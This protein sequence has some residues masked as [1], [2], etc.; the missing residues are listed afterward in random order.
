MT[1]DLVPHEGAVALPLPPPVD[2]TSPA[3]VEASMTEL[4]VAEPAMAEPAVAGPPPPVEPATAEP[5][6]AAPP[7]AEPSAPVTPPV[8]RAPRGVGPAALAAAAADADAAAP[9][10]A[11][12]DHRLTSSERRARRR[13]G[14]HRLRWSVLAVV[15]VILVAAAA[16]AVQRATKPLTAASPVSALPSSMVVPG[17]APLLPWPVVGQGAVAVPSLGYAEQSGPEPAVPIASLT[18]MANAV[19]I[20]RDHPVPAGADG[21]SI[22][23]TADDVGQYHYDLAHDESNIPIQV[24]ETLTERQMLEALLTQSA[25][26]IAYSLAVWD[27]GSEAAFVVK[28]NAL[29]ANVGAT[30]T[31][32]ADSSGY[33]PQSVSTA[34]DC[35]RI[36]AAGMVIPTFAEIV[37]MSTVSLPLV[38]EAHNIVT[39]IGSNGVV[40]IKSGYTSQAGGCMVLAAYRTINGRSTLVLASAL[41]QAV[42]PPVTPTTTTTTTVPGAPPTSAPPT[43]TTTTTIPTNDL[44]IQFPLLYTGPVVE[45]LLDATEQGVVA[46]PLASPGQVVGTVTSHWGGTAHQVRAV[47]SGR[48]TMLGWPGQRVITGTKFT[49]IPSGGAAGT[50]IGSA[51]YALGQQLASV[52]V[53]LGATLPQPSRWW[54]MVHG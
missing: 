32:Y 44:E 21:P 1:T 5:A 54:R 28:M 48:A 2:I 10:L 19:V 43:T 47:A 18:K 20:L 13:Q 29:A 3:A 49:P 16:V 8:P 46:V 41:A 26:D 53:T 35:L 38:G 27:A 14:H 31:H 11:G 37:G 39:E 15:L 40:G 34:A 36:A 25:N 51:V 22:T 6:V 4:L 17:T 7:V 12:P 23:L 9:H 24:G 45:K 42:P 33:L 50:R 30:Q 52:P